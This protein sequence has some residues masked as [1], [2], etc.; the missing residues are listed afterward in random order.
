MSPSSESKPTLLYVDQQ[1]S[2]RELFH[3]TLEIDLLTFHLRFATK[4]LSSLITQFT[5]T[6]LSTV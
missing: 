5:C 2:A 6:Q 1:F 3:R 4:L